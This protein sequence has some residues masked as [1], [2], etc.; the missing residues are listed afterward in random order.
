MNDIQLNKNWDL[1]VGDNDIHTTD[2][3]IQG[4]KIR[5]QWFLGETQYAPDS[6]I[7]YF[8]EFFVKNPRENAII[9]DLTQQILEVEG[10]ADV[11][12]L[13]VEIDNKT[14]VATIT[15]EVSTLTDERLREEVQIWKN[16][17]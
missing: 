9:N 15:F 3:I 10:V 16:M 17:E 5:L 1:Y 2:S 6:G 13:D 7:D 8:G 11:L 12:D 14:R 4:I